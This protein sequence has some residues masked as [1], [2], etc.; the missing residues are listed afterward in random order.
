MEEE[1]PKQPAEDHPNVGEGPHFGRGG[2]GERLCFEV[3]GQKR[4]EPKEDQDPPGHPSVDGFPG[5]SH[6][7]KG[8]DGGDEE[9]VGHEGLRRIFL[10][11]K[12]PDGEPSH[13]SGE[14]PEDANG[15]CP[16]V[17]IGS[18][19]QYDEHADKSQCQRGDLSPGDEDAVTD[20]DQNGD[21][22]GRC[23]LQRH[24][25]DE[26]QVLDRVK[27]AEEADQGCAGPEKMGAGIFNPDLGAS[28]H[29][30]WRDAEEGDEK[31]E[32][33]HGLR[34]DLGDDFDQYGHHCRREG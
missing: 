33:D 24:R 8:E 31:A 9:I 12:P 7:E 1:P 28:H 21:K 11:R 18:G 2:I 27:K 26:G 13:G 14:A 6:R 30:R 25:I 20:K 15:R 23:I 19:L 5:V 3:L 34:R 29:N 16:L 17:D 32:K 22:E 10:F 4:N